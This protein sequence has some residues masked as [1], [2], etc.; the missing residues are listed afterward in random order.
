MAQEEMIKQIMKQQFGISDE[1]FQSHMSH[2]QNRKL[3][4]R[5]PELMKYR[6]IAEVIE[7]KY[8][9]AG[10]KVGQK[11]VFNT[12]P[13]VL[14]A[15]ESDCP[16]CVRALGPIANLIVG[17]WDRMVEGLDPN[18]GMWSGAECLDPGIKR[19]GLGHVVFKVYAKKIQ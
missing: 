15:E 6:I 16:L 17:F 7:S 2:A 14:I 18:G 12:F 8:C 5:I 19:G 13:A 10:L 4:E 1:D 9:G 11:Y 3:A